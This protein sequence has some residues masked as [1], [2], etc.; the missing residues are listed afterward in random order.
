MAKTELVK[1]GMAGKYLLEILTKGMYKNPM[2]VLREYIQNAA[3]AI[4]KAVEQGILKTE[5]ATIHF[6][7]LPEEKIISIRDNGTGISSD[8]F[9]ET[10]LSIGNSKKDGITARGFRGIGR[11]GGLAYADRVEFISSFRGEPIRN[12][13]ICDCIKLQKLFQKG[14]AEQENDEL[15]NAFRKLCSFK[16]EKESVEEHYFEVRLYEVNADSGLLDEEKVTR[17]LQENAPVDFDAQQFPWATKIKNYF[18]EHGITIPCYRILRSKRDLPIF[19]LYSRS[20]RTGLQQRTRTNDFVHDVECFFEKASDGKPLYIGWVALTD[21]SGSIADE[22]LSGIRLRKGNILIGDNSTFIHFFP[23][24]GPQANK[25]FAG[26]VHVLHDGIDPN[27]QRDD[28][29]RGRIYDE[30][31]KV[32]S[33]FAGELNQQK[34]RG[35]SKAT[36]TLK[37]SQEAIDDAK[38]LQKNVADGAITSDAKRRTIVEKAQKNEKQLKEVKKELERELKNGHFPSQERANSAREK[39]KKV[40][41]TLDSYPS[42]TT[43]IA[44]APYATKNDL[45]SSFSREERRLYQQI[46]SVIDKFFVEQPKVAEQLREKIK[47]ELGAK[48]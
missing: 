28:F 45:P 8:N 25:M 9:R 40:T 21:F 10:L 24:E 44:N 35:T 13:M 5:N 41:E 12:V 16:Q 23:S 43:Q 19:K 38:D 47:D 2:H 11:L 27:S 6:D 37:K 1:E 46:I 14:Q 30:F 48:K 3:D 20:L 39:L 15:M 31:E 4:D 26:E 22:S 17:Y 18:K 34:R 7:I 36:S 33:K 29:E 32:L 42:L